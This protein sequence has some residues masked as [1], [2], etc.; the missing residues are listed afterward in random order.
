LVQSAKTS[1][2]IESMQYADYDVQKA[3]LAR[4]AAG[5]TVRVLVADPSWITANAQAGTELVGKGIAARWL[6]SPSVHVKAIVVDGARAYL[7]S[8]NISY[9]SLTKN[10]EIG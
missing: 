5:V 6:G 3:V 8:E 9:T 10:R 4:K 1:I 2:D 7:G